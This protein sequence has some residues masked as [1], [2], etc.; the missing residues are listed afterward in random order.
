[1]TDRF[2][3]CFIL[4]ITPGIIHDI[5]HCDGKTH[6]QSQTLCSINFICLLSESSSQ[7]L[8]LGQEHEMTNGVWPIPRV[9]SPPHL[10]LLYNLRIRA[11]EKVLL[12][13]LSSYFCLQTR[14]SIQPAS[15]MLSPKPTF[16]TVY[17]WRSGCVH[18]WMCCIMVWD[19]F[20]ST[21]DK[22][23][24]KCFL[25]EWSCCDRVSSS[26][27]SVVVSKHSA[28]HRVCVCGGDPYGEWGEWRGLI[29]KNMWRSNDDQGCLLYKYQSVSLGKW[30]FTDLNSSLRPWGISFCLGN[31]CFSCWQ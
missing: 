1:M 16:E 19:D 8:F 30:L 7:L 29:I 27:T 11:L 21:Y 20:R 3:I 6:V 12:R 2:C 9:T 18:V 25:C 26:A 22:N 14:S 31:W 24:V 15:K 4:L 17:M 28:A 23:E 10:R 13:Y 5:W